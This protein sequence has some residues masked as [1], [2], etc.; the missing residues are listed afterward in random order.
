MSVTLTTE[1]APHAPKRR[2]SATKIPLAGLRVRHLNDFGLSNELLCNNSGHVAKV[3]QTSITIRNSGENPGG[4]LKGLQLAREK[5]KEDG[6]NGTMSAGTRRNVSNMLASWVNC[7]KAEHG[8]AF[9][10]DETA[11]R[12]MTFCTLTLPSAQAHDDNELKRHGLGRFVQEMKRKHN[13]VR[14]FWRAETQANGNIHFHIIF[15]VTIPW[16]D[17][18]TCWNRIM[19]DMGY[20]APYRL[21]RKHYYRNGFK[22]TPSKDGKLLTDKQM[23]QQREAYAYGLKTNWSDPNSTDIHRLEKVK[24]C[25][26]YVCKYV[27]KEGEEGRRKIEGRIWGCVDEIRQLGQA[28]V[29]VQPEFMRLLHECTKAGQ[30]RKIECDHATIYCGDI[31]GLLKNYAP[32][33][34]DGI[35]EYYCA[36]SSWLRSLTE[37]KY[38]GKPTYFSLE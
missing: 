30:L 19:N 24:N 18:R 2:K 35:N 6:F 31:I 34:L 29:S 17:I 1:N 3:T 12:K 33:L 26:A 21:G 11:A 16:R 22:Y 5:V 13:A 27:G 4:N 15:D 8:L 7:L 32:E 9:S 25:A 38:R 23:K 36:L 14:H 10:L 28:E 20:I 37:P